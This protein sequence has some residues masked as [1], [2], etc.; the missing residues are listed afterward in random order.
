MCHD[1]R[2]KRRSPSASV[3][4]SRGIRSHSREGSTVMRFAT[5]AAAALFAA[6]GLAPQVQAH[7]GHSDCQ[8][9]E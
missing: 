6:V 8:V 9:G 7:P 5:L 2:Q 3:S 4:G 1:P